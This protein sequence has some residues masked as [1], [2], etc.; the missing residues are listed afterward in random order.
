ML[1][2]AFLDSANL[3]RADLTDVS[4]KSGWLRNADLSN[5]TLKNTD[6]G[7]GAFI[8]VESWIKAI[9]VNPK[10]YNEIASGSWDNY[11]KFFDR[12][13]CQELIK[14]RLIHDDTVNTIAYH[15][16]GKIIASGTADGI[17]RLW[18]IESQKP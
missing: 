5:A 9:S 6:F 10:N 18:N 16:D 2:R 13:T 1:D 12:K 11:V 3:Q 15:P 7:E 8:S 14:K 17:V 4:I